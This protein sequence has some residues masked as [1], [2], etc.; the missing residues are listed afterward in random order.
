MIE[1]SGVSCGLICTGRA[2]RLR[3]EVVGGRGWYRRGV[4]VD[5]LRGE[6]AVVVHAV[7]DALQVIAD[8]TD[9]DQV[10]Q[11][12]RLDVAT[13]TDVR[14]QE[15]I[16]TQL[17]QAFPQHAFVG[18]EEGRDAAPSSESYW[19][20]DPICGTWNFVSRIPLCCVNVALVEAGRVVLGVVGDAGTG[21]IWVAER[22]RAAWLLTG[23]T[24]H[25][26]RAMADSSIFVLAPGRRSGAEGVSRASVVAEA[27]RHG[28][29][30]L[31]MLGST[32]DL[33]YLAAGRVAGVWHPNTTAPLHFA[34]GTFV[35]SEAG[36]VVTDEAGLPWGLSST[37]L[38]AAATTEVHA[39]LLGL[40]AAGH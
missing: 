22:G 29:W 34:A 36:A 33:A 27:V 4:Q 1:L 13:G 25:R 9:S 17:A 31:R 38:V 10:T 40:V 12:G 37:S 6:A 5:E 26:T 15:V 19:L 21:E 23:D 11:K 8:R 32:V 16:R 24:L 39:A 14:S 2:S 3:V 7:R 35:A 28:H 30:E 18:E 20:V